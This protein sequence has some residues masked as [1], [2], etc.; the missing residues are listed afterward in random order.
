[1]SLFEIAVFFVGAILGF[2]LEKI[3]KVQ[4]GKKSI[5]AKNDLLKNE[6]SD[7]PD[8]DWVE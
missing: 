4:L 6:T 1:M 8:G 2:F 7:E 3:V 5:E